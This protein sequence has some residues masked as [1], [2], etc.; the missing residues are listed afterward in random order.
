MEATRLKSEVEELRG[1][2]SSQSVDMV[3]VSP[4]LQQA[5]GGH[6][7]VG[8]DQFAHLHFRAFGQRQGLWRAADPSAQPAG[9]GAVRR[10]Q[11]LALFAGRSA[12]RAV[13][14][15]D[16][17][18]D[19]HGPHRSRR[20]RAGAWRHALSER[21]RRRCRRPRRRNCC[22]R[23][24]KTSST[25]SAAQSRCRST[26]GSFPPARR[27]SRRRSTTARSGPTSFIGC[28]SCRCS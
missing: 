4:S 7:E 1:R 21:S 24:S 25:A 13:R 9:R 20:A 2:A 17:R 19:R 18:E 23:S 16:P 8:A 11:L 10:D 5:R 26:S 22:A 14:A 28:R 27:T 6:R 15:R 12:G 3:G